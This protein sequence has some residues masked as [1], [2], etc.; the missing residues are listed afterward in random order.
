MVFVFF[1]LIYFTEYN[2]LE[3]HPCCHKWQ[4]LLLLW[5]N[6]IPLNTYHIFFI[7]LFSN[8]HLGCFHDLAIVNN[9]TMNMQIQVFL[10]Y[11]DF[12]SFRCLPRNG[13]A[14]LYSSSTFNF[15]KSF[16]TVLHSACTNLLSSDS[17]IN[18]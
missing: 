4:D 18:F 16:H 3:F 6:N 15:L 10:L 12:I 14:R 7:H 8:R 2:T 17:G 1:C 13:I 5:L 11:S 9:T